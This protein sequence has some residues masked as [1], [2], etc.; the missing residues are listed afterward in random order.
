MVNR[1]Q[2]YGMIL[3]T[4]WRQSFSYASANSLFFMLFGGYD[5]EVFFMYHRKHLL[6]S[7]IL[8]NSDVTWSQT[9]LDLHQSVLH[10]VIGVALSRLEQTYLVLQL[11][12]H[13]LQLL[14]RGACPTRLCHTSPS[15][16]QG[17]ASRALFS[18]VS[19]VLLLCHWSVSLAASAA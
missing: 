15:K 16:Q 18:T 11:L 12:L 6:P 3:S 13:N 1:V 2:R 9:L 19:R 8:Q 5:F 14:C 10:C 7:W 4:F 17:L